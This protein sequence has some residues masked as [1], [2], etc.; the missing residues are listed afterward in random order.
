MKKL[1]YALARLANSFIRV[2]VCHFVVTSMESL[3]VS[4]VYGRGGRGKDEDGEAAAE[5]GRG[6]AAGGD[7]SV[8]EAAG[9]I[10][11][12]PRWV[13]CSFFWSGDLLLFTGLSFLIIS[14]YK[15]M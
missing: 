2:K 11:I 10:W 3:S 12:V 4:S 6:A 1:G 5:R 14:P 7:V 8:Q 9:I 13:M 15:G